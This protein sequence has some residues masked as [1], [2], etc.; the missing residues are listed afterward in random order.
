MRRIESRHPAASDLDAGCPDDFPRLI[1]QL[2]AGDKS[3][4]ALVLVQQRQRLGLLLR[5]DAPATK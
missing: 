4:L 2:A 5:E 3:D 1:R